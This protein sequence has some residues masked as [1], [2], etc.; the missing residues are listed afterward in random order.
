MISA[1]EDHCGLVI[2]ALATWPTKLSQAV[3]EKPLWQLEF[4]ASPAPPATTS[5]K[6]GKV[7]AEASVKSWVGSTTCCSWPVFRH[8]ENVAHVFQLYPLSDG[9]AGP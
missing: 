8:S 9:F 6:F 2:T 7:P 1:V 5:E 4:W 3:I